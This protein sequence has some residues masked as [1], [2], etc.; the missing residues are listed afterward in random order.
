MPK[1]EKSMGNILTENLPIHLLSVHKH[2][3]WTT[4]NSTLE[5]YKYI[6][7]LF[8]FNISARLSMKILDLS[9]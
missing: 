9:L 7:F 6:S 1:L 3:H 8:S 5:L 4:Q 2:Y